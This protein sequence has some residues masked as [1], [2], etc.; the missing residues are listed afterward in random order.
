MRFTRL[1]LLIVAAAGLGRL[2]SSHLAVGEW[3]GRV[4]RSAQ[5]L[6]DQLGWDIAHSSLLEQ[7]QHLVEQ[8]SAAGLGSVAPGRPAVG[9]RGAYDLE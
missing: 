3:L 1:L 2:A 8:H 4:A 5:P 7:A 9:G 6:G